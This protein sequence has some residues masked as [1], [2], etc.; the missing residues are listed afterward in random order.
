MALSRHAN[1]NASTRAGVASSSSCAGC[2]ADW[3]KDRAAALC[4]AAV[5]AQ[6]SPPTWA[7]PTLRTRSTW[8]V[9]RKKITDPSLT[10]PVSHPNHVHLFLFSSHSVSGLWTVIYYLRRNNILPTILNPSPQFVNSDLV[11]IHPLIL[12]FLPHCLLACCYIW[13]LLVRGTT[14]FGV[15]V[16][17]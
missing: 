8:P 3:S 7:R 17:C 12:C 1:C 6:P 13:V 4:A 16:K 15:N 14:T 5:T 11:L 2:R 9:S 10:I